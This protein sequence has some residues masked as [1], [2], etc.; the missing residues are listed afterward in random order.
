MIRC[1]EII[2]SMSALIINSI[3]NIWKIYILNCC[4]FKYRT[5][6]FSITVGI[7]YSGFTVL[8]YP[9]SL[10]LRTRISQYIPI[11][12]FCNISYHRSTIIINCLV[13]AYYICSL[14]IY[15][16]NTVYCRWRRK[17]YH[18]I[19]SLYIGSVFFTAG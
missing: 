18:I 9:H 12:M 13:P 7:P 11:V 1:F 17:L 4:I 16:Y 6:A 19:I 5:S 15:I 8:A 10:C 2:D 14:C 3:G